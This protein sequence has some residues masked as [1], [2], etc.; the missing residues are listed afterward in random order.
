[1]ASKVTLNDS[2]LF[3][4]EFLAAAELLGKDLTL[5]I[6]T[7]SKQALQ[8]R[9]GGKKTKA[10][11]TFKDHAK[12]LVLNVTNAESIAVMHGTKAE[13][14]VGKQVTF[15]PTTTTFGRDTVDC[16]R[17]REVQPKEELPPDPEEEKALTEWQARIDADPT[18]EQ[19]NAMVAEVR[20]MPD[21]VK[22]KAWIRMLTAAKKGGLV[23]DRKA[24]VFTQPEEVPA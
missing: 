18:L 12:K 24:N 23:F 14:W 6:A 22:K 9:G 15:Y 20:A 3:P 21:E 7:I 11:V 16:I 8:M 2:L 4:N 5:T 19:F 1:M 17:V 10:V 13:A